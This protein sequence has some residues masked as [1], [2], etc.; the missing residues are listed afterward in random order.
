[1]LQTGTHLGKDYLTIGYRH[2]PKGWIP[3]MGEHWS[4]N[5]EVSG[6]NLVS[7]K[8]FFATFRNSS[9]NEVHVVGWQ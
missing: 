5:P 2:H 4:D 9:L 8:V 7:V 1:M 3:Q 6:L